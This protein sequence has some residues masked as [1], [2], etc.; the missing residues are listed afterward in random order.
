MGARI[1]RSAPSCSSAR[2]RSSGTCAR[3]LQSSTSAPAGISAGR[4]PTLHKRPCRPSRKSVDRQGDRVNDLDEKFQELTVDV[5][6]VALRSGE[7]TVL[8]LVEWYLARIDAHNHVG[9]QIQAV[10]T[11]NPKARD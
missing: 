7:L 9:A 3:C 11:V 1:R 6:H 5:L 4:C 2:A 8:E 10:V